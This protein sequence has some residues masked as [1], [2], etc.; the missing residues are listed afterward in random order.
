MKM[1]FCLPCLQAW[2][3]SAQQV[4]YRV[5]LQSPTPGT[6]CVPDAPDPNLRC[7]WPLSHLPPVMLLD[8]KMLTTAPWVSY[9]L[10]F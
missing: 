9:I 8:S 4:R 6:A 7:P 10:N 3:P 2:A 1:F 5:A